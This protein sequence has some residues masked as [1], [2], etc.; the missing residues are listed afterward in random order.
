[1]LVSLDEAHVRQ[2]MDLGHAWGERGKRVQV[3][4]ISP[5][6]AA[7][8]SFHGLSLCHEGQVRLW[9]HARAN[10]ERTTDLLMPA[11]ALWRWLRQDVPGH[12]GH[13][14][15]EDLTRRVAVFE[16]RADHAPYAVAGRLRVKDHFDPNEEKLQFSD[17]ARF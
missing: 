1:M 8:V 10:G 2:D 6:L 11:E 7:K 9:P 12:H 3:A 13:P 4:S 16:A 14:T 5:G 15:A 17:S